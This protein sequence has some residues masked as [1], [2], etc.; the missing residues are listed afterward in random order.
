MGQRALV[1]AVLTDPRSGIPAK[2]T[3]QQVVGSHWFEAAVVG[4]FSV[5]VERRGAK[6]ELSG[7]EPFYKLHGSTA[8]WVVP[9]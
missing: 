9:E 1:V 4:S 3:L 7:G 6:E 5:L 2:V 8:K